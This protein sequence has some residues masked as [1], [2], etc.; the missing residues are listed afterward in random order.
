[1][2]NSDDRVFIE[3][4]EHYLSETLHGDVQITALECPSNLPSF[5]KSMYGFYEICISGIRCVL[6][7]AKEGAATPAQVAKHIDLVRALLDAIV[8][9][10]TPSLSAYNRSRLITKHV[11]FVVPG[12]QLYIP[13]LAADLREHFRTLKNQ[14]AN[15]LSPAA[16]AVLFQY[17]LRTHEHAVTP[18]AIARYLHYSAMSIGRAFDDLVAFGLA[19]VEKSGKER[20]ICFDPN[21]RTLFDKSL[22]LLRSPV[23]SIKYFQYGFYPCLKWAGESALSKL[24][25]LSPPQKEVFAVAAS[26]WKARS[27]ANN[28][29]EVKEDMADF[30][31]ETWS[32]DPAGLS[33]VLTVDPLSL[34][35]Q[36]RD[37]RDERIA[38]AAESLLERLSW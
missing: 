27:R 38:I 34:Y 30:F 35:V 7:V 33:D 3:G 10:A 26:Q 32:Y 1:M 20:R 5:L 13:E 22:T 28:L 8:I 21:R 12:N 19:H 29:V 25:D 37:H 23:R 2:L 17:I 11:A 4:L 36:Y 24:T 9:F 15:S 14:T 16:Q 31:V 6:I 18:S